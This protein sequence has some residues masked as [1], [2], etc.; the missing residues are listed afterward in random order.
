MAEQPPIRVTETLHD[1]ARVL[2]ESPPPGP[3]AQRALADLID[4]LGNAVGTTEVPSAEVTHLA[5]STAQFLQA[6][7]RRHDPGRFANARDRLEQAVLQAEA[8]APVA[9]GVARRV[10]DALANFGI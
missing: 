10:L 1:L 9:A 2:R 3:E 7:H 8:R 6:L 5:E 4:E